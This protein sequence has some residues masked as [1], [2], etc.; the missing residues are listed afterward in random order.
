MQ[1]KTI[2]GEKLFRKTRVKWI[3]MNGHFY[4]ALPYILCD[5]RMESW[6]YYLFIVSPSVLTKGI[7]ALI[8]PEITSGVNMKFSIIS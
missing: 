7:Q 5:T 8:F 2:S 1:R 3:C 4:P 6:N